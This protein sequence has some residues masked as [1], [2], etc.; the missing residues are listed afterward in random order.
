MIFTFFF[1]KFFFKPFLRNKIDPMPLI[2][3]P[4]GDWQLHYMT[5]VMILTLQSS[6][7][8]FYVVSYLLHLF[9]VCISPSWFDMQ[10]HV[11]RMRTFSKRG[12]QLTK[13]LMLQGYYKSRLKTSFCKFYG[14]YSDLVSDYKE[15]RRKDVVI[16]AFSVRIPLWDVGACPSDETV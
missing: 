11:L 5:N 6:T 8:L 15:R 14:R 16:L 7:F 3:T 2:L 10:E 1:C 13:K 12:K 9:M 4:M